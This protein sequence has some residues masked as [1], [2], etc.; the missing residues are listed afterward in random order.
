MPKGSNREDQID[1]WDG[2]EIRVWTNHN[3]I[4]NFIPLKDDKVNV[5]TL[6][7]FNITTQSKKKADKMYDEA[8]EVFDGSDCD[9]R[10]DDY[11]KTDQKVIAINCKGNRI[12]DLSDFDE[13]KDNIIRQVNELM[14]DTRNENREYVRQVQGCRQKFRSR[15]FRRINF[16][17]L[18][19]FHNIFI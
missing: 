13:E 4:V 14:Y 7:K 10:F 15:L 17:F 18:F 5:E 2:E 9:V 6:V 16:F 8:T 19:G 11:G 3:E 1:K 12:I